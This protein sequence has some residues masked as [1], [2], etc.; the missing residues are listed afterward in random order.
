MRPRPRGLVVRNYGAFVDLSRY[1]LPTSDANFPARDHNPATTGHQQSWPAAAGLQTLTDTYFR[2][3]NQAYPD[4]WRYEEWNREFANFVA[5]NSLPN[6]EI[7]RLPH[8][9]TGSYAASQTTAGLGSPLLEL[10]DNDAAVGALVGAVAG[11]PYADSTLIFVIE[12]DAQDGPDH[13]DGHRSNAF[14]VGPYVKQ[15]KVVSTAYDTISMIRTMED[16]LGIGPLGM[17]DALSTPMSD[18]FDTTLDPTT[19][20]YTALTSGVLSGTTALSVRDVT[21]INEYYAALKRGHDAAY[22]ERVM[23]GQNFS[24]EDDLDVAKFNRALWIGLMGSKPYP[25]KRTGAAH[26]AKA[27]GSKRATAFN[28]DWSTHT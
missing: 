2:G 28:L 21:R 19:F 26:K 23:K 25:T 16:I 3:F 5:S 27:T 12:D 20:K 17:Y 1:S 9:H 8:D 14:I 18:V 4:Y 15:G 7:V 11:S 24:R 22:W 6:L 10:A 13:V